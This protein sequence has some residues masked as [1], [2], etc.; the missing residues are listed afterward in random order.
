MT[1]LD[2]AVRD[3]ARLE[4]TP[5]FAATVRARLDAGEAIGA[6]LWPRLAGAAGVLAIAFGIWFVGARPE[7]PV[8]GVASQPTARRAAPPTAAVESVAPKAEGPLARSAP[9]ASRPQRARRESMRPVADLDRAPADLRSPDPLTVVA[10]DPPALGVPAMAIP[11]LEAPATLSVL[12]L[13]AG[14]AGLGDR[15]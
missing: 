15:R 2:D 8:T 1:D 12:D 11:S 14:G 13:S 10:I 5:G 6:P 4:A 7:A 9:A 3:I